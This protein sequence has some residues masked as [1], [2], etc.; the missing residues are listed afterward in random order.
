MNHNCPI[1]N[2]TMG[3]ALFM[4]HARACYTKWRRV[5]LD[6]THKVFTGGRSA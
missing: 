5:K 3:Y 4:A 2:R 6:I 1:C